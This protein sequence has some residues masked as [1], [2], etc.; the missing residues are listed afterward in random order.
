MRLDQ[1]LVDRLPNSRSVE[2]LEVSVSEIL[3]SSAYRALVPE[4]ITKRIGPRPIHTL[5]H[6]L[7]HRF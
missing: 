6:Q 2:H 3:S 4:G 7:Q 1:E 5:Q